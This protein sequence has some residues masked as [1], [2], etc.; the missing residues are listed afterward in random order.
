MDGRLYQ[1]S[2]LVDLH[3]SK[4]HNQNGILCRKPHQ[5]HQANLEINII[6]QS[7]Y[8]NAQ[9]GTQSG[10]R[11]R[12]QYS[13]RYRPAFILRSQKEEYEKEHQRKHK[14]RLSSRLFFLIGKAAPLQAD[15]VR[16]VVTRNLFHNLHCLTG[17]V[18]LC[19]RTADNG[20]GK[21]V[22]TLDTARSGGIGGISQRGKRHHHSVLCLYKEQ[23]DIVLMLTIRSL[24]LDIHLIYTVEHIEVIHIY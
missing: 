21:H 5:H 1:V 13:D 12:K 18:A 2:S 6:L 8:H 3:L 19:R 20:S 17:A 14:A 16:Q 24:G 9:I 4:L 23:V 7:A 15:I 10:Y 11:Q 22:E